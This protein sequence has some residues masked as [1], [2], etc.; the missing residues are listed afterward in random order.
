MN[1]HINIKEL[2]S[3]DFDG[4]A[5]AREKEIIDAHLREC[6]QC[7]EYSKE[8]VKLS[9]TLDQWRNE[10]LSPDL[11][12]KIRRGLKEATMSRE[13]TLRRQAPFFKVGIGGSGVLVVLLIALILS[14]QTYIKR[15][16]QGRLK[17]A[18]DDIDSPFSGGNT[19]VKDAG[20]YLQEQTARLDSSVQYEPY[21]LSID[22][23]V[24]DK[25]VAQA[26]TMSSDSSRATEAGKGRQ[27]G[28]QSSTYSDQSVKG[29]MAADKRESK[30][31]AYNAPASA[32]N[33]Q[34]GGT[35][36]YLRIEES[37]RALSSTVV[38]PIQE[39]GGR[40]ADMSDEKVLAQASAP[41]AGLIQEGYRYDETPERRAYRE[42]EGEVLDGIGRTDRL[43]YQQDYPVDRL[44]PNAE[45][46]ARIEENP[47]LEAR[48]NP[49]STFSIDVDTTSYSNIRRFLDQG[50]LPP[51]DAVRIE[52]M[53]NYFDYDYPEPGWNQPFS[54]TTQ[55]AP[56]P[57]NP[58]NYLVQIGLKGKVM[59]AKK[60]PPSN[61]VFLIDVSGS[62]NQSNK[63]PLLKNAFRMLVDQLSE[64]ERVAI[65]VYAGSAGV[66]LDS[67]PGSEK[68]RISQA[69]DSLSAGGSTAGGAGIEMAYGIA[70]R[71]F[72]RDGNNR[73]ILATDGDF[74]VG[75]SSDSELVRLIEDKRRSGIFLTILGFG[76]GNYKDAK[77]E[78]IADK[79]NGNYFY[80]DSLS[81]GRKV[82]VDELGSTIFTIAKD[83]KLQVEFNPAEVRA[84][85]LIGY[86]NRALAAQDFNDDRKDAGEVGA[87][88]T[89]TA[90]YEV[91]PTQ[92]AVYPLNGVDQLKYQDR[93]SGLFTPNDLL[94]VKLRYKEPN[95]QDSKLIKKA[96]HRKEITNQS[97]A[98]FQFGS[99]VA[100]F[101]L[102]LRG[103]AYRANASYDHVL[104][105]ARSFQ[106]ADKYGRK[107]EFAGL[108]EKARGLDH[109]QNYYAP[110]EYPAVEYPG[111][112]PSGS[113][114]NFKGR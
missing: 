82:L 43:I 25:E 98:D 108:V 58:Q 2:M 47:F 19:R 55:G 61:L 103:S 59:P 5:T 66:V 7:R 83:V 38:T 1:D 71:N 72:I 34:A 63:L 73:I 88:H 112:G 93:P 28:F 96:V 18:A 24:K 56:C 44:Q 105:R 113:N 62:M 22:D 3:A 20:S 30:K 67:T 91:V 70:Q 78:Q 31:L 14:T 102:L 84:Y 90:F 79:G 114:I 37:N 86:E 41:V 10:D 77:M 85:R 80:I 106:G 92:S 97:S 46:Y 9:A 75:V 26:P 54:I 39:F 50:Q 110:V 65:V 107:E 33:L 27:G 45:E 21:Y 57:W 29:E 13:K 42:E 109:R 40:K 48:Y 60:V 76:N 51:A 64:N 11:E 111:Y 69:I 99:A 53:V 94:T 87:G 17:G 12:Q 101:G 16:V 68:W 23:S 95:G 89:V 49:L 15:G 6:G 100:E 32:A 4:Q 36:N 81:E 104:M 8:L 35:A 52:E 74:N